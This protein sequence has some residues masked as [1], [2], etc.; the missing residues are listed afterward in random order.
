MGISSID[1]ILE[2]VSDGKLK[3][4]LLESKHQYKNLCSEI[5][6]QLSQHQSMEEEPQDRYHRKTP[7]EVRREAFS[8]VSPTEYPI[9]VNKRIQKYK[10]KW[11]T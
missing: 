4:V 3:N 10:E 9:P 2:S 11:C 8:T 1:E 7:V 6:S 5:Y